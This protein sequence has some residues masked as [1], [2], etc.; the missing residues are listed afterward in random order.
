M[1]SL[2]RSSSKGQPTAFVR[3]GTLLP[4]IFAST[5]FGSALLLFSVQPMF[6]KLVLPRLGGSPAVW[7]VAMVFFQTALLAGYLYAHVLSRTLS[8][9]R[10]AIVHFALLAATS[11]TLPLGIA[12]GFRE[13]PAN[14]VTLWLFVL[15]AVSLGLPFAALSATAPL[16]Q[17]WFKDTGHAQGENPYVLYAASNLGSFAALLAYPVLIEPLMTLPLQT[18]LWSAGFAIVT[19]AM[20][21]CAMLAIG[22]GGTARAKGARVSTPLASRLSWMALAAI[23]SGLTI[24]LTAHISTDVAA[25]PFLWVLPLAIYLLT[26]VAVFRDRPWIATDRI[27]WLAVFFLAAAPP[28]FVAGADNWLIG[29]LFSVALFALLALLC[30]ARLFAQRPDAGALTEF[31]LWVSL[32]GVIGGAFAGLVAPHVFNGT[33]EFPLLTL[34]AALALPGVLGANP[35]RF[36][37]PIG[38]AIAVAAIL[39]AMSAAGAFGNDLSRYKSL[40]IV[41][42]VLAFLGLLSLRSRLT[43]F[44]SA[45]LVVCVAA[46]VFKPGNQFIYTARGFFGVHRIAEADAGSV[47]ELYHGTTLHGVQRL[48]TADGSPLTGKPEP[49]VYYYRGSPLSEVI[50]AARDGQGT[51]QQAA[52]VG[53][54]IGSLACY[55]RERETWTF[56]EI[57]P[58]VA[59][60]ARDPRKFNFLS[61]CAPEAPIVIGDARL[62]LAK[63]NARYNL[64]VLDAFSSDA[65]PAHLLTREAFELYLGKLAPS[66]VIAVHTSNRH[67][68]LK[69]TVAAVGHAVGLI[70][71]AKHDTSVDDVEKSYRSNSKVVVLARKTADLAALGRFKGWSAISRDPSV[72]PWTDDYSNLLGAMLRLYLSR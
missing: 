29:A 12:A 33:Y 56:F 37:L 14:G 35:R 20:A 1:P 39:I 31:Y 63:Q 4:A 67:M 8:L 42:I 68:E 70:A 61:E 10:A 26:F 72:K 54:G 2:D 3:Q 48:K 62:T 32:G 46:F 40:Y 30:H 23:P 64:I 9:T 24:A 11:L 71:F 58:I 17:H 66:G 57:D 15:F 22:N 53:L 5:L 16:L 41:G 25:A 45:L 52:F 47:R 43:Y 27:A 51:L 65:I 34:L 36:V 44:V 50:A 55:R 59:D 19:G 28:Q 49:L 69:E 7:S 6:A 18:A 21:L 60:I 13:P 38:L